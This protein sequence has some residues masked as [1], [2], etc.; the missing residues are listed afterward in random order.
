MQRNELLAA[1]CVMNEGENAHSLF[2]FGPASDEAELSKIA[3]RLIQEGEVDAAELFG[4]LQKQRGLNLGSGFSDIHPGWILEKLEGESPRVLGILCRFLTGDK[5]KYLIE[6]LPESRRKLLPKVNESYKVAPQVAEI[7]RELSAKK[8]SFQVPVSGGSFSFAHI[9][10]L[11]TDDLRTVFR[12]LGIEEIRRAFKDV[13][14]QVLRAFLARFVPK[15]AREIRE[16]IDHG[17]SVSSESR[18]E[19][20]RHLVSLPL[21]KLPVEDL[22]REIGYSV[23]AQALEVEDMVWADMV[24]HKLPPEEGYRLKRVLQDTVK[25]RPIA[26]VEARRQEIL[27]RIASLAKSGAIRKYWKET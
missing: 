6:H 10:V 12:D 22:F 20:Q 26:A 17:G 25:R 13:E 24:Y 11:K 23:F 5:V 3:E 8:L 27:G 2:A 14:P 21:E 1:L 15:M 18:N 19:A 7:V 16:R 4:R 9:T